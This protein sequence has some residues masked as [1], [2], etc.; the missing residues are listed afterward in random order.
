M[1]LDQLKKLISHVNYGKSTEMGK[2]HILKYQNIE[3]CPFWGFSILTQKLLLIF[4][5]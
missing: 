1:Y 3:K 4:R 2:N 5:I